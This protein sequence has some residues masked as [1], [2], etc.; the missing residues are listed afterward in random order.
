VI[1]AV[2]VWGAA[3]VAFGL[4]GTCRWP[5]SSWPSRAGRRDLGRAAQHDH[6]AVRTG[7]AARP[8]RR[9]PDRVVQGGPRLGDWRRGGRQRLRQRGVGRL[10]RLAASPA[11]CCCPACSRLPHGRVGP[12]TVPIDPEPADPSPPILSRPMPISPRP[13]SP[14]P[15]SPR[16]ISR[17]RA[18]C[19][20]PG[21]PAPPNR[22][23]VP[24][25]AGPVAGSRA[26]EPVQQAGPVGRFSR[27]GQGGTVT[28][29]RDGRHQPPDHRHQENQQ[30]GEHYEHVR[31]GAPCLSAPP[32]AAAAARPHLG[33]SD[34]M[35]E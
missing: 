8:A 33:H 10:R 31:L 14:R 35:T 12:G 30:A 2:I 28:S 18:Q 32:R 11:R 27:P 23:A 5:C 25:R 13:I 29:C 16:P 1:I 4:T 21:W 34:A 22:G 17:G 7:P 15:I 26:N 24:R 20:A 6:P 19:D 9:H 3:I